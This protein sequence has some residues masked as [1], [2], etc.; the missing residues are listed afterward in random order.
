MVENAGAVQEK[1]FQRLHSVHNCFYKMI[2]TL[3]ISNP[4][5]FLYYYLYCFHFLSYLP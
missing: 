1:T 3:D 2:I 5:A 4:T